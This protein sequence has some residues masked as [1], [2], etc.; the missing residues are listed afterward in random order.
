MAIKRYRMLD[1]SD[2]VKVMCRLNMVIL[3]ILGYSLKEGETL[4]E[5]SKK[6]IEQLPEDAYTFVRYYEEILYAGMKADKDELAIVNAS[7]K[8][9]VNLLKEQKGYRSI[10]YSVKIGIKFAGLRKDS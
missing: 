6:L 4:E 8:I 3:D 7:N 9:L 1:I 10:F 2:Q 5:Y